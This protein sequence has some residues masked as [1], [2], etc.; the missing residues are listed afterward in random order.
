VGDPLATR[1]GVTG[2]H[3]LDVRAPDFEHQAAGKRCE[4]SSKT[5]ARDHRKRQHVI[6]ENDSTLI[7]RQ[8]A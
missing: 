1:D 3:Q 4:R 6:I 7:D 2:C 8:S 5:T